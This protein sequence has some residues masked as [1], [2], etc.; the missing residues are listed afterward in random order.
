[1]IIISGSGPSSAPSRGIKF[2]NWVEELH[3]TQHPEEVLFQSYVIKCIQQFPISFV[4]P[5]PLCCR[6]CS[7]FM[8]LTILNIF[9]IYPH[10][11]VAGG[12]EEGEG[13]EHL[14]GTLQPHEVPPLHRDVEEGG[15]RGLV[16]VFEEQR[17]EKSQDRLQTCQQI[18]VKFLFVTSLKIISSSEVLVCCDLVV[19]GSNHRRMN[20]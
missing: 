3:Y 18:E 13:R 11:S 20:K 2:G 17:R 14:C 16:K 12:E 10:H 5:S 8:S 15:D 19:L 7:S 9:C 6:Y 1:M 4:S